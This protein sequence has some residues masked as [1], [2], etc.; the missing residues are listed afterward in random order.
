MRR[1]YPNDSG[2]GAI[3]GIRTA[4]T[5]GKNI[6]NPLVWIPLALI[7]LL[8]FSAPFTFFFQMTDLTST[9]GMPTSKAQREIPQDLVPKY[10]EAAEKYKVPWSLLASIHK[11]ETSFGR[12]TAPG[13]PAREGMISSA[14]AQGPMQFTPETW[15]DF[16]VDGDGDGKADIWNETDAIHSAANMLRDTLNKNGGDMRKAVLRYNRSG[17]YADQVLERSTAY[18]DNTASASFPGMGTI[19]FP[20]PP[21]HKPHPS[22]PFGTRKHP[23]T[24]V[25][26]QHT[27]TDFAASMG[28]PIMAAAGGTVT[29]AGSARGYGTLVVIDHGSF[30][31]WYAHM[32]RIDVQVGQVVS[33]GQQIAAVGSEGYSTGP[34]LHLEVRVNGKPMD[35]MI[36]LQQSQIVAENKKSEGEKQKEPEIPNGLDI[37][38]G[39]ILSPN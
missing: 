31:T 13:D 18:A 8:V 17:T 23:V 5:L 27:G 20:L 1:Y 10:I 3:R 12:T 38:E 21:P 2:G 25:V 22:S 19:M 35:P 4:V 16:G 37:M 34:H 26:K 24:G 7:L 28:T 32:S 6:K 33:A 14:N 30:E 9:G 39:S 36:V 29:R 15:Q 11:Q